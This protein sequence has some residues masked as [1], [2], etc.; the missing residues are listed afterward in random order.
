MLHRQEI[1]RSVTRAGAITA[2]SRAKAWQAELDPE[3]L[4][5][6]CPSLKEDGSLFGVDDFTKVVR[7]MRPLA[8]K[9]T[10]ETDLSKYQAAYTVDNA[11][12]KAPIYPVMD[13]VPPTRKHTFAPEIDASTLIDDE[14][15]FKAVIGVNWRS[16]DFQPM[17]EKEEPT[18]DNPEA[19]TRK[20]Q[21]R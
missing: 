9:L 12:V 3:E 14:A 18:L 10:E 21:G 1:K 15:V 13:L 20:D 7:E 19:S 8:R 2:L 5:I 16:P 4:A 6:G 11:K 17:E